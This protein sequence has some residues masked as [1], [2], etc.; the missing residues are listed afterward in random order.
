MKSALWVVFRTIYWV[1]PVIILA[2]VL[3]AVDFALVIEHFR[4]LDLGFLIIGLAGGLATVFLGILRWV[5][6][7]RLCV[8]R[9]VAFGFGAL[10]AWIGMALT[11]LLP[12]GLGYDAY[13][14]FVAVRSFGKPIANFSIVIAEK[15]GSLIGAMLLAGALTIAFSVDRAILPELLRFDLVFWAVLACGVGGAAIWSTFRLWPV[16]GWVLRAS[17]H[18]SRRFSKR[19]PV[20]PRAGADRET[21]RPLDQLL[22]PWHLGGRALW[23]IAL[24][25]LLLFSASFQSYFLFRAI[26]QDVPPS[27]VF[28][29]MP[30][31]YLIGMLPITFLGLGIREGL[32]I[33]VF[34]A[35]GVPLEATVSVTSLVFV[36]IVAY[37]GI[38]ALVALAAARR[39]HWTHA[40]WV[41]E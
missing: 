7:L 30:L 36:I 5:I 41:G 16:P 37:S 34:G 11:S 4:R 13:R 12:G 33:A 39:R 14:L 27:F 29:V 2:L 31:I 38:G 3:R 26:G 24:S 10:H 23:I 15:V 6:L 19:A 8:C 35:I 22:A 40:Q 20:D 17:D 18:L 9:S 25:A 32:Y 1:L 21:G 28:A